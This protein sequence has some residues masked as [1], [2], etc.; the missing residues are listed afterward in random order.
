[1]DLGYR[2]AITNAS[3]R[4]RSECKIPERAMSI[5]GEHINGAGWRAF[6]SGCIH[7]V[8]RSHRTAMLKPMAVLG[9][10]LLQRGQQ[11]ENIRLPA[12]IAHQP[13]SPDLSFE[14]PEAGANLDVVLLQ[15]SLSHS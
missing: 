10:Q 3:S 13:D 1:M 11:H 9:E 15:Q 4:P 8:R 7:I 14:C 5:C 2:P 6:H 12:R